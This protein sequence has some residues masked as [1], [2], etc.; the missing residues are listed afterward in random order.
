M[1]GDRRSAVDATLG[2]P[3]GGRALALMTARSA[4][5]KRSACGH[6][7]PDRGPVRSVTLEDRSTGTRIA[8]EAAAIVEHPFGY[9]IETRA[10][11]RVLLELVLERPAIAMM[12][13]ARLAGLERRSDHIA[14]EL[15]DGRC[16]R[17]R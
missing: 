2:A 14:A 10:L 5:T 1:R 7:S 13:P 9:G 4:C 11:R 15:D 16:L 3:F 12:A 17:R 8:Y 6:G